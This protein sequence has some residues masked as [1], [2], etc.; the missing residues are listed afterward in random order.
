MVHGESVLGALRWTNAVSRIVVNGGGVVINKSIHRKGLTTSMFHKFLLLGWAQSNS[1]FLLHACNLQAGMHSKCDLT[2]HGKEITSPCPPFWMVGYLCWRPFI[3]N[4]FLQLD[5]YLQLPQF[6]SGVM[7]SSG[8][9]TLLKWL[10]LG[11]RIENICSN[12]LF[13][14]H[15]EVPSMQHWL[16]DYFNP[17]MQWLLS[18]VLKKL[19]M[20]WH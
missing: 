8:K 20:D 3:N 19:I 5:W 7:L 2:K 13:R 18:P 4:P 15:P 12:C 10:I 6:S 16:K 11:P 9:Q 14:Q 1:W 17:V